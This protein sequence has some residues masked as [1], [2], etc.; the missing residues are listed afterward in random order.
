MTATLPTP[1][2]NRAVAAVEEQEGAVEHDGAADA[3]G[4]PGNLHFDGL[5][6]GHLSEQRVQRA[7]VIVDRSVRITAIVRP[8]TRISTSAMSR[9]APQPMPVRVPVPTL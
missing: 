6:S 9:R 7:R 3:I 8:R 2:D 5:A 1:L 4:V